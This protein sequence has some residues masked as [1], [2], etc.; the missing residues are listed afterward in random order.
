MADGSNTPRETIVR[1]LALADRDAMIDLFAEMERH[2]DGDGAIDRQT[3]AERFDTVFASL[4]DTTLLV[5]EREGRIAGFI[6]AVRTWPGTHMQAAWW[7]KEVYAAAAARRLG[8]GEALMRALLERARLA[9]GERVDITTD[10]TNEAA[11]GLYTRLGGTLTDKV[12]IRYEDRQPCPTTANAPVDP[13]GHEGR[14]RD[15]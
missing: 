15:A 9:D 4:A 13:A 7:V 11:I 2:Y 6:T 5:A 12:L 1:P 8:V 3:V 14:S 10:R